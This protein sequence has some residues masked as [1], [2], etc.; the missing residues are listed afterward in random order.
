M[1]AFLKKSILGSSFLAL[2]LLGLISV[3]QSQDLQQEMQNFKKYLNTTN[4]INQIVGFINSKK[5]PIENCSDTKFAE[6]LLTPLNKIK[7][8]EDGTPISGEW[9]QSVYIVGCGKRIRINV[10]VSPGRDSKLNMI[11]GLNGT[12]NADYVLSKDAINNAL[13][14]TT[15]NIKQHKIDED[16]DCKSFSIINTNFESYKIDE[17]K[18]SVK[19]KSDDKSNWGKPFW[20]TWTVS[21]CKYNYE[22]QI[23]FVPDATGT[24]IIIGS[25]DFKYYK[26]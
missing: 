16:P 24:S 23:Y 19:I 17:D 8:G 12:T 14:G 10:Y 7:L 6:T 5:N 25:K 15:I 1:E 11:S 18:A 20:E 22:L 4:Y 2:I 9:L 21:G 3:A 13:L 26:K